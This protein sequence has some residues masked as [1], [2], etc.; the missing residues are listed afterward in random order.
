MNRRNFFISSAAARAVT[1]RTGRGGG[2]AGDPWS[3]SELIEPVA[4][5]KRLTSDGQR[6]HIILVRTLPVYVNDDQGITGSTVQMRQRLVNG[7]KGDIGRLPE[8]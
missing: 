8:P 4:L 5:V 6:I 1:I 7:G 2:S 3:Q